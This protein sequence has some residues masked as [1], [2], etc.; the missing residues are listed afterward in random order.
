MFQTR[1]RLP[2]PALYALAPPAV[3]GYQIVEVAEGDAH[4]EPRDVRLAQ[5]LGLLDQRDGDEL[6]VADAVLPSAPL[7]VADQGLHALLGRPFRE[8]APTHRHHAGVF[9][10]PQARTFG[11]LPGRVRVRVK[12]A[13]PG[14]HS[15]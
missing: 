10:L 9:R 1:K 6:A 8:L 15:A 7:D 11:P 14:S 4:L 5:P 12:R 3:G 2:G 13:P